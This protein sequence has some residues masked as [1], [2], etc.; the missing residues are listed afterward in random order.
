MAV[1]L[2]HYVTQYP[3]LFD[4]PATGLDPVFR[5]G[6]YGVDLFFM[7]SG[8]VITMS[9]E[10]SQG[11][12]GFLTARFAR[13][14]PAYWAAVLVTFTVCHVGGLPS[15]RIGFGDLVANLTMLQALLRFEHVDGAYWSLQV[16]WLFYVSIAAIAFLGPFRRPMVWLSLWLGCA[17]LTQQVSWPLGEGTFFGKATGTYLALKHIHLF[18]MG[19]GFFLLWRARRLNPGPI[20][21]VLAALAVQFAAEGWVV[22]LLTCGF[23]GTFFL[24]TRDRLRFLAESQV[25]LFLG[26]ISYSLYL[27]HQ[28]NGYVVIHALTSV[29][30]PYWLAVAVALGAAL[31]AATLLNRLVEEPAARYV[32]RRQSVAGN[33]RPNQPS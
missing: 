25:L 19:A 17:V 4:L 10:H 20:A 12:R 24:I 22:G 18:I 8:F 28:H 14:Y 11:L 5:Y 6:G 16:E 13:L 21:L 9:L 31:G 3:K 27:I 26:S 1:V 30:A 33:L 2:F 23:A 29:G 15:L 32:R 7:I